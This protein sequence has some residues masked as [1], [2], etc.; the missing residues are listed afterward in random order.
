MKNWEWPGDEARNLTSLTH[1]C[2]ELNEEEEHDVFSLVLDGKME[3]KLR[4]SFK[5][6]VE[7]WSAELGK[8]AG[9]EVALRKWREIITQQLD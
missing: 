6:V 9:V 5:H 1:L 7:K 8:V 4:V 2:I 3:G